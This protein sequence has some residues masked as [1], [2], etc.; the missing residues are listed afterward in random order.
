MI[1]GHKD[2]YFLYYVLN[3]YFFRVFFICFIMFFISCSD[4][5]QANYNIFRYNETSS[6]TSLDPIFSNNQANI[7]A[8][9]QI[10]NTLIELDENLSPQPSVANEWIVSENGLKYTFTLKNNIYYHY[11]PCFGIDSTRSLNAEDFIYSISRLQDPNIISPGSWV[12]DYIDLPKTRALNDTTLE[13]CLNKPFPGILGLLSMNYFSFIPFEAINYFGDS[14]SQNPIGTGPF[15]FKYWKQNEKLLLVR[16]NNYFEFEDNNQLP[17][18]DGV[19]ISFITQKESVFMNFILGKFDFVSGLDNNFKDEFFSNKGDIIDSYRD[20]FYVLSTPYLN[21]EYLGIN[22][23]KSKE[24]SNPLMLKNFRKAINYSFDRSVMTE[25]LRNGFVVPANKGF[26][27]QILSECYDL[28]G[29]FYSPDSVYKLLSNIPDH[30]VEFTLNTTQDY[31]DICE[32]I[33]YSASKF[34]ININIEISS[35]AVHRDL[36]STGAAS[37]FRASWIADYPD[38]ENFLSL[39][40]SKNKSPFGPNYTHFKNEKYDSL[41][42]SSFYVNDVDLRCDLFAQM[43]SILM[44]ESNIIPLY[45]DYVVRLVSTNIQGMSI[46]GMNSLSL[47]KVRKTHY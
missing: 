18:L 34:G 8:T 21:T 2:N 36:F 4:K 1:E 26:V 22:I 35:P 13:I 10:F 42:L 44:E 29:F 15:S 17:Y 25:H 31:L 12:L 11:S 41:Y 7:W 32:F 30:N 28:N 38:P 24:V 27:P 6:I 37:F 20:K 19:A 5:N 16:N 45:Y 43:E 40:Y 46:N 3:M 23:E 14:F 33:Q 39:F 47:K 9:N